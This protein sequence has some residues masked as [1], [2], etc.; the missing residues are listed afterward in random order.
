MVGIK[1]ERG[2]GGGGVEKFSKVNNEVNVFN[3]IKDFCCLNLKCSAMFCFTI[4]C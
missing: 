1:L 2:G 4:F 3:D